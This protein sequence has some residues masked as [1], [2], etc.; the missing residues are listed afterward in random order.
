MIV[1]SEFSVSVYHHNKTF[2]PNQVAEFITGATT[3]QFADSVKIQEL[4]AESQNK[5]GQ[6]VAEHH[7][8]LNQEL[9]SETSPAGKQLAELVLNHDD[10]VINLIVKGGARRGIMI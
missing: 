1:R 7:L 4:I 10:E 6:I 9:Q 5:L 3:T 2:T 8:D